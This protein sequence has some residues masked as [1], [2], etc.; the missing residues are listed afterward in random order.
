MR[1]VSDLGLAREII[2]N[3]ALSPKPMPKKISKPKSPPPQTVKDLKPP[4][5]PSK[6]LVFKYLP[7][8]WN[9]S[10]EKTREFVLANSKHSS[11]VTADF[12]KGKE[13]EKET[14]LPMKKFREKPYSYKQKRAQKAYVVACKKYETKA[15]REAQAYKE[16]K[17]EEQ[18]KKEQRNN[19]IAVCTACHMILHRMSAHSDDACKAAYERSKK[20]ARVHKY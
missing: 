12:L 20:D 19:K 14:D 9:Q 13:P 8:V 1:T 16:Y 18:L 2:F 10:K 11:K 15:K 5:K 3:F 17:K 4:P 6:P 7:K